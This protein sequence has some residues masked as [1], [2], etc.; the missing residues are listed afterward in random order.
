MQACCTR[1]ATHHSYSIMVV[2]SGAGELDGL[3]EE[4][5]VVGEVG[6]AAAE[7]GGEVGGGRRRV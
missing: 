7:G 2:L 6:E 4:G 5:G 1:R 3:D